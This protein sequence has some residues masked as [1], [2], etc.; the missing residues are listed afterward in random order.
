M[1]NFYKKMM[2]LTMAVIL[3]LAIPT[4]F[5]VTAQTINGV[6]ANVSSNKITVSG[7][8]QAGTVACVILVY[9][10]SGAT[11]QAMETCAVAEDNTYSY[12]LT[13]E[14]AAGSYLIKAADYEG[15]AYA[16]TTAVIAEN[17]NPGG[18]NS[19]PSE[20]NGSTADNNDTSDSNDS[21][22]T[23]APKEEKVTV[24]VEYTVVKGDTL[25]KIAKKNNLTLSALLAMNPQIKNPNR[26]YPGQKIVVSHT[27]KT[28]TAQTAGNVAATTPANAEYYVVQKGDFLSRIARKNGISLTQLAALNPEVMK[29][30]YIYA[31]QKIRV[32]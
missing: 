3:C 2:M 24:A 14:F 7:T 17:T 13:Q 29:Q 26:I 28:V 22:S 10:Q 12:T 31:G 20:N 27:T 8:A 9:D 25:S 16:S 6:S 5:K 21:S 30:K 18:G 4:P 19:N 23:E 1:K 32:K 11:L 15:G